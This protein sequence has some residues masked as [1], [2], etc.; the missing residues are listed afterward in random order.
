MQKGFSLV[1]MLVSIAII[2]ILSSV[3]IQGFVASRERARLEEDVAKVVQAIRQAQNTALAPSRSETIDNINSTEVL[4]SI[5]VQ[6]SSDRY[7]QPVYTKATNS[8]SCNNTDYIPY[9]SPYKLNY[10]TFDIDINNNIYFEFTIPFADTSSKSIILDLGN[11]SKTISID[12]VGLI[13]VQ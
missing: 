6:I 4:C 9:D 2:G 12:S 7:I 13:K 5:G 8:N 10:S 1:E 11:L 3:G